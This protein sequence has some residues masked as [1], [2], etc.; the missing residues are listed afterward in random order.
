[1]LKRLFVRAVNLIF[2]GREEVMERYRILLEN[3]RGVLREQVDQFLA[4]L[5]QLDGIYTQFDQDSWYALVE[6]V[7]VFHREDIRFVFKNGKEVRL[8]DTE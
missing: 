1:M 5:E 2:S 6:S 3:V 4:Q 8:Q 7:T